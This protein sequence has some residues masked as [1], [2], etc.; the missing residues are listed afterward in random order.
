M[1]KKAL[2]M[3]VVMCFIFTGLCASAEEEFTFRNGIKFG[4][5]KSEVKALEEGTP[6]EE[7][8]DAVLYANQEAAGKDASV[9][10]YFE[11][12]KLYLILVVFKEEHSND[13]LFIDDFEDVDEALK[14]KYGTPY[15][16]AKKMWSDDTYQSDPNDWG[17]AVRV[18]DLTYMTLFSICDGTVE[19]MHA[20]SG[21]NYEADHMLAYECS[22]F[23]P[24]E[25][26]NTSGI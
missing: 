22:D 3:F 18:G 14:T 2:A 25:T 6:A 12:G 21:D 1:F 16:D 11:D 20:L 5:S 26:T 9:V 17:F 24:T 23:G 8:S 4:M 13:N 7:Q 19:I 15:I 10:Y